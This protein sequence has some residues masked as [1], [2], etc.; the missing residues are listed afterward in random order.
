MSNI[1]NFA[2]SDVQVSVADV[3]IVQPNKPVGYNGTFIPNTFDLY[4]VED[5][6]V[7]VNGDTEHPMFLPA[8]GYQFTSVNQ[9]QT[10][11]FTTDGI[12]YNFFGTAPASIVTTPPVSGGGYHIL[13]IMAQPSQIT[14]DYGSTSQ[15]V[16]TAVR[17]ALYNNS[18]MPKGTTYESSDEA[19]AI[20]NSNGLVSYV[21]TGYCKIMVYNND[22]YDVVNVT[23]N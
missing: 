15:I 17:P 11:S 7:I 6:H 8:S 2:T 18:L 9:L 16:V 3:D 23:C 5:C 22:Y 20:V 13:G 1:I 12:H 19:V 21:G 10:L 14:L 4:T